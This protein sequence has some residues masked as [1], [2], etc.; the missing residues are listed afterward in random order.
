[1]VRTFAN[2]VKPQTVLST[3]DTTQDKLPHLLSTEEQ[4]QREEQMDEA[5]A[6]HHNANARTSCV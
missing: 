2:R 1:M 4:Q 3:H 6:V 5:V